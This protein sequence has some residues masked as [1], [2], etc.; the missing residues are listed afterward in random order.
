M[1]RRHGAD[2]THA[3]FRVRRQHVF[4]A[5]Q[6]LQENPCY[7]DITINVDNLPEDGISSELLVFEEPNNNEDTHTFTDGTEEPNYNSR[8]FLPNPVRE[9]TEECAVR[10]LI[11]THEPVEWPT[12]DTHAINEFQTPY[13]ATMAFPMLFPYGAG[14]PTNPARQ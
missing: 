13:L 9:C 1:V 14:D 3:D 4:E 6:W 12:L 7:R 2:D 10:S 8:S 11:N 5:Q